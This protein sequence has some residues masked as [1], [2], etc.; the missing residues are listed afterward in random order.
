M[1][2]PLTQCTEYADAFVLE[3]ADDGSD[4]TKP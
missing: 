4:R 1:F 3:D 2:N